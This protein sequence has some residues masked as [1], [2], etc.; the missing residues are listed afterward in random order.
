MESNKQL[1]IMSGIKGID[2]SKKTPPGTRLRIDK[3]PNRAYQWQRMPNCVTSLSVTRFRPV[4]RWL[5]LWGCLLFVSL[6]AAQSVEETQKQL[7]HG[8]YETVIRVTQKKVDGGAYQDDWRIMLIQSLLATGR[9][10][11]AYT[12]AVAGA[13]DSFNLTLRLLARETALYQNDAA[14]AQRQMAEIKQLIERRFGDFQ[15]DDAPALG[16]ALLLLG[17]EPRLVLDNCFRRAEKAER[18]QR[19]AFLDTGQ[20]ALD[21]HDSALAADAFRAGL[22]K[23]P[24]DP[25]MESGLARAFESGDQE[26]M[27][28]HIQAALAA[29]PRHIPSLLLL[30]NH[31]IDAEEYDKAGEQLAL[32]LKVNPHCPE[33]LAYQA[34]LA[35]LRNDTGGA[36]QDRA[37]ALQFWHANPAVDYLIGQKLARKYRFEEAAAEQRKALDFD[38]GS[39]P[40]RRE[41]A[42]DLLRLG[43][44]TEG[45]ELAQDAHAKDS[46]DVTL[47]NLVTLHD[48]MAKYQTLTNADF[49]V[50]MTPHEAA[51]YGDRVMDLLSRAKAALCSK[52]GVELTR[53]TRVEIFPEQKDF[54]VRTFGMPGNPGYLGVCFGSVITAN[55]PASQA[56]NPAN[57]EDVLWH[58]FCHVVTLNETRN[59]MPRWLSEGISVF[60]ERQADPTWGERMN[61]AYREMILGGK[62]TPLS[63]L[64]GAFLAPKTSEDLL[65]AYY[66]SSLVV[67]FLVREQGLETLKAILHDLREGQEVN[68]AITAHTVPLREL[69]NKF[70]AFARG[71]ANALAPGA[72]LEKPPKDDDADLSLDLSQPKA[73]EP[74]HP[75]DDDAAWAKAHPNNYYLKMRQAHKLMDDKNWSQA[76]PLLESVAASYAGERRADNPLW[77]LAQTERNL[78]DTNAELAALDKL[79]QKESDF[80]DLDLRLIELSAARK[81][82]AAAAKYANQLL[83]VN[84]LIAA[85]YEALARAEDALGD[86]EQAISAY[87][88]LLLLDP[89][90]PAEMHFQLARLLHA[91]GD[92][93]AEAKR[94]VLQ[95]LEEA[96]RFR[97]AQRLLLQIE[98]HS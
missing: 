2:G 19:E 95:A 3:V 1:A 8:E 67:E 92:A 98:G 10:H 49:I 69:E 80:V 96:P 91:R 64:S 56:P 47:Y 62:L 17:V 23:F 73:T 59:R 93:E 35:L 39:L 44:D 38:P 90:D 12:N 43:Q 37:D 55:S 45:W 70:D 32:A 22:K 31:M 83:A 41:L 85:P 61:L 16:Q 88:R 34:V 42:E 77:L 60:E 72:D 21:K 78:N 26:E 50:H 14:G 30:A 65:F 84:P 18:P 33:A 94:H 24:N 48:Q 29:N 57:W 81:D 63:K 46:Y 27:M 68:R 89:A 74:T 54:A 86:N 13:A 9:Y 76:R 40:A 71:Q 66:E 97:E 36:Q 58:E 53:P 5:G 15:N 28:K 52:Y 25:D 79:A 6:A 7:L 75:K 20:L 4:G 51:L 87:R 11:E 82:W